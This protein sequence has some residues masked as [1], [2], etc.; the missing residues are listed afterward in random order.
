MAYTT[1]KG[2]SVKKVTIEGYRNN[3]SSCNCDRNCK[4]HER[5]RNFSMRN[6]LLFIFLLLALGGLVYYLYKNSKEN[7]TQNVNN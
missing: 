3:S 5:Y 7:T 1:G 2:Q 6:V 4:C